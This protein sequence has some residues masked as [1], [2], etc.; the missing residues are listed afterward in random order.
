MIT[1]P[2]IKDTVAQAQGFKDW[3]DLYWKADN[4]TLA[5]AIDEAMSQY[6]TASMESFRD[7]LLVQFS[8]KY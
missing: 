3:Q 2:Q 6:A 4:S 1:I 8:P 7:K 5:A